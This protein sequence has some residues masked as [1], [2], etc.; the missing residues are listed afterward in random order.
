MARP[1]KIELPIYTIDQIDSM[2]PDVFERRTQTMWE[3][4]YMVISVSIK[5]S[6]GFSVTYRLREVGVHPR[7]S[8]MSDGSKEG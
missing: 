3:K 4:G 5:R 8:N 7:R 2:S 6:G 1:K